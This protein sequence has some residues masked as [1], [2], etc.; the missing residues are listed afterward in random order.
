MLKA[1]YNDYNLKKRLNSEC[2]FN[3]LLV[4][5]KPTYE[6]EIGFIGVGQL[7]MF[8]KEF[9]QHLGKNALSKI[10]SWDFVATYEFWSIDTMVCL[11]LI[12]I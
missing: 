3:L 1:Q 10:N 9:N 11:I 4:L 7:G 12:W 5:L 2:P 8:Y 6:Q